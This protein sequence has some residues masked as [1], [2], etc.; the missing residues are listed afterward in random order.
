M[1]GIVI[2]RKTGS[3]SFAGDGGW[4]SRDG[5]LL[6][7]TCRKLFAAGSEAGVRPSQYWLRVE[8]EIRPTGASQGGEQFF[9]PPIVRGSPHQIRSCHFPI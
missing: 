7:R 5:V 9:R 2:L 6:R 8:V 1:N 3:K 4:Y